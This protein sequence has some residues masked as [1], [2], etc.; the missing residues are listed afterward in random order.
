MLIR[1]EQSSIFSTQHI[2]LGSLRLHIG[3]TYKVILTCFLEGFD[4]LGSSHFHTLFHEQSIITIIYLLLPYYLWY[5]NINNGIW[6]FSVPTS[7]SSL[8]KYFL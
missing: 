4:S 7:G 2:Q 8:Q 1:R 3:S 5:G 6:K